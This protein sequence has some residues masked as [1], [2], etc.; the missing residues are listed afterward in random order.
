RP[1]PAVDEPPRT[2]PVG[3]W[4]V[5]GGTARVHTAS[6]LG[7]GRHLPIIESIRRS[8][9]TRPLRLRDARALFPGFR[10]RRIPER[11]HQCPPLARPPIRLEM[12]REGVS[13]IRQLWR[14]AAVSTS[15]SR[16]RIYTSSLPP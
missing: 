9:R 8:Y 3:L 10:H 2:K 6:A 16:T 13:I 15:W 4:A 5:I 14:V 12:L 7:H 1:F 11:A